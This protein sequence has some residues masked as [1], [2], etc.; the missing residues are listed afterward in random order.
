MRTGRT[1]ERYNLKLA[2]FF[3]GLD[4]VIARVVEEHLGAEQAHAFDR[5][6]TEIG[7]ALAELGA[8]LRR[9]DPT[10][11]DALAHGTQ[12]IEHQL[13]GLRARFHRAQMARD[14]AVN[15]QLERAATAL[16]PEKTLQER[17]VNVTSLL[18]RHGR[19]LVEWVYDA[20]DLSTNDH[21][22]VYL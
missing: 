6:E 20:I 9:F 21:H 22:V 5:A 15:R 11:A 3:A 16:Y 8:N 12:K 1:L 18:A 7:G 4:A 14:R 2:D 10:L 19:Y 17:H 13:A